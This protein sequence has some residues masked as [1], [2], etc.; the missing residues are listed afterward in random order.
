MV[1]KYLLHVSPVMINGVASAY[2]LCSAEEV[3]GDGGVGMITLEAT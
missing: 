1:N 3:S 2:S